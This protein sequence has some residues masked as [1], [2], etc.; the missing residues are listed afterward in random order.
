M[1]DAWRVGVPFGVALFVLAL[2]SDVP[3]FVPGLSDSVLTVT[4]DAF[5]LLAFL[6]LVEVGRR[7]GQAAGA[8]FGA[9]GGGV[10]GFLASLAGILQHALLSAA[11]GYARL[12][13]DR[14]G[15]A[16]YLHTLQMGNGPAAMVGIFGAVLAM[17]VLGVVLGLLG[18][19]VGAY[20]GRSGRA[21]RDPADSR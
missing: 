19:A 13:S 8:G 16:Q 21:R 3:Y 18:G 9:L 20:V 1:S 11:P 14:Y 17:T 4:S 5:G 6:G 10:A 15:R 12:V 2:L 7:A